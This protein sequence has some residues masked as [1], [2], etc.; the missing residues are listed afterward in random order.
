MSYKY[1]HLKIKKSAF[2]T[3]D[4]PRTIACVY[5]PLTI[6]LKHNVFFFFFITFFKKNIIW[7]KNPFDNIEQLKGIRIQ[8]WINIDK[9]LHHCLNMNFPTKNLLNLM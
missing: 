4:E 7:I 2:L 8:K 1:S 3:K 6:K 5:N 9:P